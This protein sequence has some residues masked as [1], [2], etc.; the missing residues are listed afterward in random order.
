MWVWNDLLVALI[1]LGGTPSVAPMTVTISNLVNSLG[2]NWQV[3]TAGELHMR[4]Q[5]VQTPNA[6]QRNETQVE[7]NR[8]D[9]YAQR[10]SVRIVNWGAQAQPMGGW[11]LASVRSGD[12][13][14]FPTNITL[15]PQAAITVHSG[16]SARD[17][18]PNDLFWT[19]RQ[20]WNNDGDMAVL[21]DPNGNEADRYIYPDER[22]VGSMATH[23]KRL[24]RDG[25][26]WCIVDEG[27]GNYDLFVQRVQLYAGLESRQE[28]ARSDRN[29]ACYPW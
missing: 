9:N 16:A 20:V 17:A 3:L 13:F 4:K 11:A 1:Y 26:T 5:R 15:E 14:V 18:P 24:L 12:I 2:G 21:F 7:I 28:A 29:R 8:V 19:D 6:P 22:T 23:R 25:A 27:R 10:E